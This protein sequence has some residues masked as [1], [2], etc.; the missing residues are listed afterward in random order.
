VA[1][2][3]VAAQIHEAFDIHGK[4]AA[5]VAFHGV[6]GNLAT[7]RLDLGLGEVL[8]P[9]FGLDA[10]GVANLARSGTPDT[11]DC[12][13][14]DNCMFLWRNINS[15]YTSHEPYL[16]DEAS[17]GE[18]RKPAILPASAS[19]LNKKNQFPGRPADSALALLVAAILADN[20]HHA[21]APDDLAVATD[22]LYG[23]TNFHGFTYINSTTAAD[24]RGR[25]L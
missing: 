17:T 16:L 9:G 20:P 11:V 2:A 21:L 1:Y 19:T 12:G 18:L 24:R 13:K 8:D 6:P 4:G 3:P 22:T 10:G 14:R 25:A 7:N 5:Q 23:C 15:G